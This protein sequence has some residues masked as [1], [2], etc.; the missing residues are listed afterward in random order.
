MLEGDLK[1]LNQKIITVSLYCFL[2]HNLTG[3][4][5]VTESNVYFVLNVSE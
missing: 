1:S 4:L 3:L 5:I 2:L